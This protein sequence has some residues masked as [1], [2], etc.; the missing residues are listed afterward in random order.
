MINLQDY[1]N[2]LA[3][4][5]Y[6]F[7]LQYISNNEYKH[8]KHTKYICD[9]LQKIEK[10]EI[11]RVIFSL[12]PRHSKSETITKFFPVWYLGRNPDKEVMI[13][14]YSADLAI[15]FGRLARNT[16]EEWGNKIFNVNVAHDSSAA[17]KWGIEGTRGGLFATGVGG[18]A[19]GK[20]YSLG[21]IDDPIKNME[22]AMSPIYQQRLLEWYKSVFYTRRSPDA[23]IILVMTRWSQKDLAQYLIDEMKK[24]GEQWLIVSFPAIAEENDILGRNIGETLWP[25]RFDFNF[26]R[27]AKLTLGSKVWSSLYQQQPSPEGGVV[28]KREWFQ[29]Y[30]ILPQC[31]DY[32]ISMDA[33]FKGTDTSDYVVMQCWGRRDAEYYLIDQIRAKMDFVT[34]VQTFL[35]FCNK[36]NYAGRKFVE[37]KANGSAIINTLKSKIVGIIPINPQ[38]SKESRAQA[39]TPMLE[40]K[41]VYFQ[42]T[43][44]I[45]D[46][47]EECIQFPSGK[48][49]DQIDAM[50]QALNNYH[51]GASGK[52]SVRRI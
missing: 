40:S 8:A 29:F 24:D 23:A 12:P 46:F 36:H 37:D 9:I 7:F 25:E 44:W 19:T 39:I 38:G 21:I 16:M 49:D 32:V 3:K 4:K 52:V 2:A 1:W 27:D 14:S 41:N 6:S 30:N 5:D 10:G 15:D 11:K 17:N 28:F 43:T 50:S 18:S 13:A 45:G 22:E 47:I 31:Q 48:H 51:S 20:G 35:N 34:T 33:T 42:N 26:Y